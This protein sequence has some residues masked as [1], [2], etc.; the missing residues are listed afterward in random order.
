MLSWLDPVAEATKRCLHWA[1]PHQL[2]HFG[3]P[4]QSVTTIPVHSV[5]FDQAAMEAFAQSKSLGKAVRIELSAVMGFRREITLPSS[6]KSEIDRVAALQLRATLP[7]AAKGLVWRRVGYRE[8]HGRVTADYVILAE[9]LVKTIIQSAKALGT[10]LYE[11]RLQGCPES[12]YPDPRSH[13]AQKSRMLIGLISLTVLVA[14]VQSGI[15][16]IRRGQLAEQLAV[17]ETQAQTAQ[18]ALEARLQSNSPNAASAAALEIALRSF[19]LTE[20]PLVYLEDLSRTLPASV[21]ISEL[22]M[23]QYGLH[24]SGF[25]DTDVGE[26]L[27]QIHAWSWVESAQLIGPVIVDPSAGQTRFEVQIALKVQGK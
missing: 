27:T 4:W 17:I 14:M 25:S 8:H 22:T 6:A 15:F 12:L 7:N 13:D 2:F 9:D 21:W 16:E 24:L 23:D 10:N 1:L 11:I 26:V 5:P 3:A 19:R 18:A 20:F